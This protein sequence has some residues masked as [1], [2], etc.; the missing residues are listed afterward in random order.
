M[1]GATLLRCE[2]LVKDYSSP[3]FL[4]LRSRP[5][6]RALDGVDLTIGEGESVGLVGESGCGKSTLARLL[7]RLDVPTR[8]RIYFN[9]QDITALTAVQ[10]AS[11][12]KAVQLIFQ[13]PRGSLNPRMTVAEI[14]AE[15]IH[16]HSLLN[17]KEAIAGRVNELMERVGLDPTLRYRY[18]HEFSG[19]Q[20]QRIGIARAIATQPR[21][22]ICD[23]A[24][25][26]LDVSIQA[27]II[28]LLRSLCID[29]GMAMLFISHD[30][31][32]VHHLADRI[33]V[34]QSGSIV[35]DGASD[36]VCLRPQHPHT[37]KLVSCIP[38]VH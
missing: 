34:M 1:S 9:G 16:V 25:S 30:L 5:T 24:V 3:S 12:R 36:Q 31:A 23:E 11:I 6:V 38:K 19:G 26:A 32:V 2:G 4:G 35:E 17:G 14:I 22:L 7:V 33:V 37:Q 28:H 13:D 29:L 27:Q 8:G 21:L 10:N 15:P 18:P 20:C